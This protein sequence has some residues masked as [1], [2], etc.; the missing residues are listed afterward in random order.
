MW[1]VHL[2]AKA[3]KDLKHL[4]R[5][6]RSLILS[7]LQKRLQNCKDPRAFGKGLSGPLSKYWRYRVGDYR[8][9]CEIQ[10]NKVRVLVV[11]IGHRRDVYQE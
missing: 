5:Q 8:I 7:Y 10:D 2:D 4:D 6:T 9:L 1:T 11:K 3:E